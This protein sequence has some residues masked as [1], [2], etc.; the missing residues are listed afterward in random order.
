[1]Q[2]M[3]H[4]VLYATKGLG[5]L[6]AVAEDDNDVT[7]L[8]FLL[9]ELCAHPYEEIAIAAFGALLGAWPRYPDIAWAA[10]RLTAALALFEVKYVFKRR[11]R[12]TALRAIPEGS[13]RGTTTSPRWNGC[14]RPPAHVA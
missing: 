2:L 11:R 9:T 4:P 7:P 6:F 8:Q 14:G 3:H 10:M 13:H 5:A 1:M 12:G